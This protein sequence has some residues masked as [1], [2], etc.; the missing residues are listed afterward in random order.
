M[1]TPASSRHQAF[2]VRVPSLQIDLVDDEDPVEDRFD[3][4]KALRAHLV[5]SKSLNSSFLKPPPSN[6]HAVQRRGLIIL[7]PDMAPKR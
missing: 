4:L 6:L 5:S 7:S 3:R 1:E 2:K